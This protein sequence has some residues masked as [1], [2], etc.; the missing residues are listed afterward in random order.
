[1]LQVVATRVDV[2]GA[3]LRNT[4][5][6]LNLP[7]GRS[8]LQSGTEFWN[9]I[10]VRTLKEQ[11]HAQIAVG[12]HIVRIESDNSPE[13]GHRQIRPVLVQVFRSLMAVSF[14]LLLAAGNRLGVRRLQ[15]NKENDP[16]Q[17]D[18]LFHHVPIV[19]RTKRNLKSQS[20]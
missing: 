1:M 3:F 8:Q 16:Q 4:Q 17:N 5:K 20:P 2:P 14:D 19:R 9:R 15:R 7:Q 12:I 18:N 6:S 13:F 11:H 10:R